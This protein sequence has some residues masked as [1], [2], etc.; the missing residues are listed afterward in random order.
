MKKDWR[1]GLY[2]A[3]AFLVY[4][5]L[6][7]YSPPEIDWSVTYHR[8]DK[9]PFGAYALSESLPDIF[10]GKK[11]N[12][13]YYTLYELYDT[14]KSPS[15]FISLSTTFR[16]GREDVKALLRN[17]EQGGDAFIA[18]Q[19]FYDTFADTLGLSTS[20]YFFNTDDHPNILQDDT[21]A[22]AFVNPYLDKHEY[23]FPRKNTHN[24]FDEYDTTRTTIIA[25]NDLKLPVLIKIK[26]G[27]GNFIVSSTPLI[28]TN[29]YLLKDQSHH[30][31]EAALSYLALRDVEWTE[32]YHLG[33]MEPRSF[34]RFVLSNEALRWAYTITMLSLLLF[35]FFE[36]KRK[37]RIIPVI[38][39][40]A[41]TT[42]EFVRTI[43]NLYYQN[44]DHRD[45]AEK[46]VNF[47]LEQVRSKF[48]L[49]THQINAAFAQTLAKKSGH[50]EEEVQDL[51]KTIR[52]IQASR[53][54]SADQLLDLNYKIEKFNLKIR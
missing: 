36:A 32:F 38:K 37:Q 3:V 40:L 47:L 11:I 30:Y 27:K 6:K 28:F 22:I 29:I 20:D 1:Y 7:L 51:F 45:I 46:K 4:V 49:S 12:Q 41:N 14:L 50:P 34:L 54:I 19:Y 42:L 48:L 39:P 17:V 52:L 21:A 26:W 10:R 53:F 31:A 13:T 16:P 43:G 9:N 23:T 8:E 44:S 25:E 33:R 35:M 24:Y 5:A 18:A 15:N 2:L